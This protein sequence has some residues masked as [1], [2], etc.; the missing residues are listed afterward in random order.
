VREDVLTSLPCQTIAFVGDSITR[1]LYAAL[2]HLLLSPS[3]QETFVHKKHSDMSFSV[4]SESSERPAKFQA[5]FRWRPYAAN[6]T[7]EILEWSKSGDVPD[8]VVFGASLWHVLHV[9][10]AAEY[11]NSLREFHQAWEELARKV[12]CTP[13]LD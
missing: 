1:L 10:N 3:D 5:L 13:L 2:H 6:L 9:T 8:V 4:E 11:Q 12:R 7:A